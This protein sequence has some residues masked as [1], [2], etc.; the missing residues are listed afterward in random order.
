MGD[1][2]GAS[3]R[4]EWT[5]SVPIF[6]NRVILRQIG[7]AV[8]IPFGLVI[9]GVVLLS[10]KNRDALYALLIIGALFALTWGLIM[11]VYRGKYDAQFILDEKGALCRT[12]AGQ[13]K[14]NRAMNALTAVLG[15]LSGKPAAAGAGLLAQS[16]QSVFIRWNRVTAVK[17]GQ[18]SRTILLRGG[19]TQQIAL[20]CTRENYDA[21]KRVIEAMVKK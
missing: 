18:K 15:L 6:K 4:M 12:Q 16:R 7:L 14:K 17:Y 1:E 8:G 9:I 11:A 13:A 19:W 5:V 20:F 21:A 3:G 10:G 2:S